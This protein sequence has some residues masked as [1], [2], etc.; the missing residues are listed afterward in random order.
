MSLPAPLDRSVVMERDVAA[1]MDDG[2]D[3]LADVYTPAGAGPHPTVLVRS[4]YGRRGSM[5]LFLGRV[6]AERGYRVVVQ[7]CRGTFGSGGVFE[8][9]SRGGAGGPAPIRWIQAQDWFDGRLAM[10]GPSYLGGVQWAVADAVGPSLQALCTHVT[11]SDITPHWYRG[12]SFSLED[13]IEWSCMVSEQE[14]GRFRGLRDLLETRNRRIDRVIDDLPVVDLDQRVL[15]RPV[16]F[17]REFVEHPSTEDPFWATVNHSE[18]LTQVGAPVLQVG[19]W[20]DIFLPIQLADHRTLV[21]AGHQ[22]RLVIGPW[23]HTAS[24]GFRTQL[25]ESLRWLD[26]HVRDVPSSACGAPPVRL[27][28]MGADQWRD[29]ASWPPDGYAPQRWHLHAGGRLA[30]RDPE[31][32]DADCYR[33]DPADP[34]PIVGGTLLRRTGGRRDQAR[35]EARPDVLVYTSDALTDDVDVIG[36]VS[37]DVHVASD[38]DHFD[39]FVRL[40]DVDPS[41]RSRNVCD[42]IERVSPSRHPRPADGVWTVHVELWPTAQ[43]FAAGHRIRVQ[44]ASGA[45]PRFARNLGTGEPLA[46]ATTIG[47]AHQAVYHDPS[48]RSAINLPMSTVHPP[49][50]DR[51]PR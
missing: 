9:H 48:H 4:P 38:L 3:L 34:T 45:H 7:S 20:Y 44:V 29:V 1:P 25:S 19:G 28:V 30:P 43:R 10:N 46:T 37:A 49:G 5:G 17:W 51:E 12:G 13:A 16:S 21:D 24:S 11:Y 36:E 47:V 33:Y 18:R 27:F 42:G 40:C 26:E 32:S 8:P 14:H 22:P 2:V 39:V 31:P 23:T 35:T 6:F 50:S 41:G 15:G